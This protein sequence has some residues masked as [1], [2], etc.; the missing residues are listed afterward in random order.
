MFY[1]FRKLVAVATISVPI[2]RD[3][4]LK[5]L[6]FI[7]SSVTQICFIFSLKPNPLP[8]VNPCTLKDPLDLSVLLTGRRDI[9]LPIDSFRRFL[10][11]IEALQ[12]IVKNLEKNEGFEQNQFP[13]D[14]PMEQI[15]RYLVKNQNL[16]LAADLAV[17]SQTDATGLLVY[18]SEVYSRLNEGNNMV[19]GEYSLEKVLELI[20]QVIRGADKDRKRGYL[21]TVAEKILRYNIQK[22]RDDEELPAVLFDQFRRIDPNGLVLLYLKYHKNTVFLMNFLGDLWVL[23]RK[24]GLWC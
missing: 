2:S 11:K 5:I 16:E 24:Q 23:G 10:K 12:L 19:Y 7:Q 13:I 6:S 1:Q 17:I 21:K 4:Y 20:E 9:L 18:L 22:N 15:I 3:S 14:I 8:L